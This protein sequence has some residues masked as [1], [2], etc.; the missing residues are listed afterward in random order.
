[1]CTSIVLFRKSNDWPIIIGSNRDESFNRKSKFPDRHWIKKY[2][3]VI[4]G[5]DQKK[6]GAWIGVNDFGL[7]TIIHNG[8]I[9]KNRKFIS[10]RGKIV[11]EVLS[12]SNIDD[13]LKYI[14]N[15]NRQN[16]NNFNLLV[17]NNHQIYWIKHDL[18]NK[19]IIIKNIEE[20][21]S[22]LTDKDINDKNDKKINHYYNLFLSSNAPNPS[23]NDWENWGS[24]LTGNETNNLLDN[25]RIC[26][27]NHKHNYGT[28][29]SSL[30]ALPNPNKITNKI[31]FKSTKHFPLK[32]NYF[33]VII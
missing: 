27:A 3:N 25:E 22:V 7:V 9:E 16:Y 19:N 4:A 13:V 31:I 23:T 8:K 12:K 1:M 2:P 6:E 20:E 33:D 32:N 24:N 28:V 17:A 14:S 30:I 18:D 29:S 5:K 10:S 15:L 11:L 26:F 21:L